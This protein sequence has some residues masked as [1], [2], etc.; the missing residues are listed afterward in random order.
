M[1][2]NTANIW[3]GAPDQAVTGAILTADTA[4]A[5][6]ADLYASTLTG[7]TGGGYVTEDGVSMSLSKSFATVKDWSGAI[8]KRILEEF[9]GTLKYG[10]LEVS[11]FSLMDTFGEDSVTVTAATVSSGKQIEV[12]IGADDMPH[13]RRVFRMKDGDAR[14]IIFLPD[15]QV[16]EVDD[17]AFVKSDAIKLNVTIATYPDAA[18]KS[19]YIYTDDGVFSA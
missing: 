12:A 15:S 1:A 14:V 16:T 9:D 17:V 10:H 3:S 18:G 5:V 6:P 19:I 8:V 13:K 4:T 2:V 7:F 11:E